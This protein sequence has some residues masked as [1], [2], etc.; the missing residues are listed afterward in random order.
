MKRSESLNILCV[1]SSMGPGGAERAMAHLVRHLSRRHDITLATWEPEGTRSFYCLPDSISRL[2]LGLLSTGRVDRLRRA[3]ARPLALRQTIKKLKP[4][5][6]VSFMDM[7][8]VVVL[9]GAAGTGCPVVVA[10]RN[11]PAWTRIGFARRRLRNLAYRAAPRLVVQ[12]DRVAKRF[13][14]AKQKISIIP[15]P[16][17]PQQR[18]AVPD[19]PGAD[20]RWRIVAVGRLVWQKGFDRLIEAFAEVAP[21]RPDWDLVI[22]GEGRDRPILEEMVVS[23][24]LDGR[25]RMPG[26]VNEIGREL[27]AAHLMAFPSRYEGF[28]NALAEGLAAGLPAVGFKKVSGVEKLIVDGKTGLLVPWDDE[29]GFAGALARLMDDAPARGRFGKAAQVHVK[30]WTPEIV[31]NQWE[32]LL[33]EVASTQSNN[34]RETNAT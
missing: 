6:V 7:T 21:D 2:Q 29:V 25:V 33:V 16:V 17:F 12:T 10:E 4:D 34:R 11:D 19:H 27:S 31:L 30:K 9:A 1:I 20:G 32:D 14:W 5:V 8:N 23:H 13:P 28:P 22:F 24:G 15:N 3:V 18:N 26:V